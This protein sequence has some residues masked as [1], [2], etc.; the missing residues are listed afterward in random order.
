MSADHLSVL[1]STDPFQTSEDSLPEKNPS[2]PI[3]DAAFE[4]AANSN[5]LGAAA[6]SLPAKAVDKAD[7]C[8]G[9]ATDAN[10]NRQADKK[11][12]L[13]IVQPSPQTN[14]VPIEVD[15]RQLDD[16]HRLEIVED[17]ADPTKTKLAVFDGAAVQLVSQ[18]EYRGNLFVPFARESDGLGDI[19]LPRALHPY[20]S[21]EEILSRAVHLF[22]S[23]LSLAPSH[24]NVLAAFVL[25][26]WFADGLQPP[27]YLLV[28][29]LP[30]SGKTTL[31]EVMR[32]LCRRSMLVGDI[33]AAAILDACS[34]FTPTLLIDE[35]EWEADRSSRILRKQLRTG[36]SGHLLAKSLRKTQRAFGAKILSSS[37]LPED[38][39]LRSRCVHIPMSETERQDLHKPWDPEIVKAADEVQGSL[40]QLRLQKY[41]SIQWRLVPGAE[42]L[43]PRSR[44]LLGSLLAALPMES[45][46]EK[47]LLEFFRNDHNPSTRNLLS[48]VQHAVVAALFKFVHLCPE[49]GRVQVGKIAEFANESLKGSGERFGLTPRKLSG[50][51]AS[52]GFG[53]ILRS[54]R[55]SQ[56]ILDQE[57]IRKIHRLARDHNITVV[58]NQGLGGQMRVCKLCTGRS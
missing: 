20:H 41:G 6:E 39:A 13:Q 10:G 45:A 57:A 22:E 44:D 47:T 49:A 7:R 34:R 52:L 19:V 37:E 14:S 24:L 27:V 55:G 29:G 1:G 25:Y 2:Q 5:I 56:R 36:T 31:L 4:N 58:D 3:Y 43:R 38:A 21:T 23:C 9:E 8:Q 48:P 28:T 15:F 30:Q 40:L 26:S 42:Q 46:V 53:E 35:N 54:S 18:F 32:L 12:Q 51:L 17:P 11:P 50:L 33:S 16:G